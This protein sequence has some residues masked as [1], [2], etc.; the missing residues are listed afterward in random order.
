MSRALPGWASLTVLLA[1]PAQCLFLPWAFALAVPAPWPLHDQEGWGEGALSH[2]D[3]ADLSVPASSAS[4]AGPGP[5]MHSGSWLSNVTVVWGSSGGGGRC[6]QPSPP[7]KGAP[8]APPAQA[9]RGFGQGAWQAL[10]LCGHVPQFLCCA[11]RGKETW[12]GQSSAGKEA[13]R[14]WGLWGAL[15]VGVQPLHPVPG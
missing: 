8:V 15:G 14:M 9:G 3:P 6:P 13:G 5:G 1:S 2:P 4:R 7:P 11:R 12:G 10:W